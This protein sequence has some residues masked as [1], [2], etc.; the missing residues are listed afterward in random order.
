MKKGNKHQ[1]V[2][3]SIYFAVLVIGVLALAFSV[4]RYN[5]KERTLIFDSTDQQQQ[6][7]GKDCSVT[8][9]PRG[10]STDSW[11]KEIQTLEG[12][13]VSYAGVIY[14]I[15]V[16]NH[17]KRELADWSLKVNMPVDGYIN[18]AWC[19]QIEFHQHTAS[20]EKTQTLDL[21]TCVE[22]NVSYQVDTRMSGT[23]LMVPLEKDDY[24]IYWPSTEAKEDVIRAAQAD[25]DEYPYVQF[26]FIAY[27]RTE[28]AKSVVNFPNAVLTYQLHM[29]MTD[30]P[31]AGVIVI[32]AL[33]WFIGVAVCTAVAIK[34]RQLVHRTENDARIIRQ[35]M[36]AFMG[37]IDAKDSSTNGHSRRVAVYA[38]RIAK[39]YGM[40]EEE[41]QNIYYMGLM[42]DC[43]KIRIPDE[44]LCKP[45]RLTDE[46][47]EIMKTHTTEGAKLLKDFTS[48]PQIREAALY[49]HERYDGK[50]YP[51]GLAGEQI[52]LI[53]RVL[54][55]ADSF[56]AM[57]SNR[58]YR[59][60]L[61]E[62]DIIDE[63][64]NNRGTQ[65]DPKIADC[66]LE[67]LKDGTITFDEM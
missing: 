31:W 46:E 26:G 33:I 56:D 10:G 41:C 38:K 57:N 5:T 64:R 51:E 59:A 24:F 25:T 43:G 47:F 9:S 40:S 12:K 45:G 50:G 1:V 29:Q 67:L 4:R 53:A 30:S 55:V 14:D 21:R 16:S 66:M 28:E 27:H 8:I 65:F 23:D 52:P 2:F 34:T 49:H 61:S 63:I 58:C 6:V 35:A 54:C 42:H 44:V 32:A 22:E 3:F 13:E 62:E 17:T 20:E 60:R 36:S 7:S 48:I 37:F 19:G 18:N 15:V 11:I 39:R